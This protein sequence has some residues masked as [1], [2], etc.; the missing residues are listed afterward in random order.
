MCL[1]VSDEDELGLKY[2][3]SSDGEYKLGSVKAE[4]PETRVEPPRNGTI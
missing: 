2:D 3:R 4:V 1:T